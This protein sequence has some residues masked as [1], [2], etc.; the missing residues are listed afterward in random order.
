MT[1]E[2]FLPRETVPSRLE[3]QTIVLQLPLP[4]FH[5]LKDLEG[6]LIW[7]FFGVLVR[8]HTRIS[9]ELTNVL[10]TTLRG[11]YCDY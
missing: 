3:I 4:Q 7:I 9:S 10:F 11:S 1:F 5:L 2:C 6:T 8:T